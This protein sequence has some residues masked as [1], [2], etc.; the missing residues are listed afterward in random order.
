MQGVSRIMNGCD[1]TSEHGMVC[2]QAIRLAQGMDR[3][4]RRSPLRVGV[5]EPASPQRQIPRLNRSLG[6]PTL[7]FGCQLIPTA[8]GGKPRMAGAGS[9]IRGTFQIKNQVLVADPSG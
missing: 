6:Q 5:S 4:A 8:G 7:A 2:G 9:V 3:A 1:D